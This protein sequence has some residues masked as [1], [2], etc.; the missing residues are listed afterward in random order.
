MTA[1]QQPPVPAGASARIKER[2]DQ[3]EHLTRLLAYSH[4]YK[5][6]VRW[7]RI[8]IWGN[9]VMALTAPLFAV[10]LPS[11]ASTRGAIA[12][13]WLVL[14]R[15][16]LSSL[17][18][19]YSLQ[20]ANVQE[21]YDTKLF[22][23]PWNQALVGREPVPDDVSA[24]ARRIRDH[25]PYLDWYSIDLGDTPWPG[26]V[27]LCQRQS[28][29][30]SRRDHRAYGTFLA[31]SGGTWTLT[32]IV[33]ALARDMT[34]LTFLV[35][36]FLPSAAALL[37]TIELAREH[38]QQSVKRRQVED[39]IHD[40][41]NK[42]QASPRD[43]PIAECQRLQDATYLLRRDSPP[44]PKWFYNLRRHET[45]AVTSDGTTSLRSSSDP[46]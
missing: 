1:G 6:A 11:D 5:T 2:Q 41:W 23:L 37:D 40:V 14:G 7:R 32:I 28:A 26:D 3:P 36:L 15:T 39:D 46:S 33:F 21:L 44:V 16:V 24:A 34:L 4:L 19:S 38:W 18:Q 29:V 27:L 13:A 45:A 8:R 20:G 9:V 17:E 22:H 25:G 35:A 42:Y 30:W 12:A 31:I 43:I 10:F